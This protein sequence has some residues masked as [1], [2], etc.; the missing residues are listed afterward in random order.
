[1]QLRANDLVVGAITGVFAALAAAA[2]EVFFLTQRLL[3]LGKHGG[4]FGSKIFF[5]AIVGAVIGAIVGFILG[6]ILKPRAPAR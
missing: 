6:G 2:F 5:I 4:G 3:T 1:M